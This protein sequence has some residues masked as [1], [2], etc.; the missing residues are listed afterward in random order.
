MVSSPT[1]RMATALATAVALTTTLPI[2]TVTAAANMEIATN[3]C[4]GD[5][6]S[7]IAVTTSA[8]TTF[9]DF[10]FNVRSSCFL[11]LLCDLLS[12]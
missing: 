10:V 11:S 5:P 4:G 8:C 3:T 7:P 12:C 6:G 9:A 1:T 2:M